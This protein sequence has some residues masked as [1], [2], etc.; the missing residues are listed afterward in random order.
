[1]SNRDSDKVAQFTREAGFK[2]PDKPVPLSNEKVEFITKMVISELMELAVTVSDDPV[3]FVRSCLKTDL[4]KKTAAAFTAAELI[5]E[6]A[7]AL[8]DINYYI[9]DTAARHGINLGKVFDI[10]HAANMA[11]KWS[12]GQFHRRDDG[13]IIKPDGWKEPNIVG[14]IE[15]QLREGGI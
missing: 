13:K 7:D 9:Y 5:A 3:A 14:E 6:Q 2:I 8:T 12:D 1:M 15:R 4:P 11:K 10:V